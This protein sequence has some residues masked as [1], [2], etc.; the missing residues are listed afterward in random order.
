[1]TISRTF[2][3]TTNAAPSTTPLQG[4]QAISTPE[5]AS[6]SAP[7]AVPLESHRISESADNAASRRAGFLAKHAIAGG[8]FK[9]GANKATVSAATA[10]GLGG[11]SDPHPQAAFD[12]TVGIGL[13]GYALVDGKVLVSNTET[14]MLEHPDDGLENIKRLK[15]CPKLGA[16]YS[17]Y[18]LHTSGEVITLDA[19]GKPV[20]PAARGQALR[21]PP[22]TVDFALAGNGDVHYLDDQGR[23]FK[24]A[25]GSAEPVR[26]QGPRT[27]PPVSI[28]LDYR[29]RLFA[30]TATNVWRASRDGKGMVAIGKP[31]GLESFKLRTLLDGRVAADGG[32]DNVHTYSDDAKAWKGVS[33]K[34]ESLRAF[35]QIYERLRGPR[36]VT[37]LGI[38]P[39]TTQTSRPDIRNTPWYQPV[40]L[41]K[42][43]PG[44]SVME[45]ML[46]ARR[47][48]LNRHSLRA[49]RGPDQD[50]VAAIRREVGQGHAVLKANPVLSEAAR[51]RLEPAIAVAD[52][53]ANLALD[54]LMHR[55]GLIIA[56][57]QGVISDDI[58]YRTSKEFQAVSKAP[59][60]QVHSADNVLYVLLQSRRALSRQV[61]SED[62]PV[63][64]KLSALLDKNVMIPLAG[65]KVVMDG[66]Q[67]AR[68]NMQSL[69]IIKNKY[70]ALTGQILLDLARIQQVGAELDRPENRVRIDTLVAQAV[71]D[72]RNHP[73]T[74]LNVH[75]FSNLD[76]AEKI[77]HGFDRMMANM[78][79][80]TG[81]VKRVMTLK[82]ELEED[83]RDAFVRA[84]ADAPRESKIVVRWRKS[85]GITTDGMLKQAMDS[86]IVRPDGT[87]YGGSERLID[88]HKKG[89]FTW[90][91]VAARDK[92]GVAIGVKAGVAKTVSLSKVAEVLGAQDAS[93]EEAT[94]DKRK[95]FIGAEVAVPLREQER[96]IDNRVYVTINN[97]PPDRL[98]DTIDRALRGDLKFLELL[99]AS[100][101]RNDNDRRV[102]DTGRNKV[103]FQGGLQYRQEDGAGNE[104]RVGPSAGSTVT[105]LA[106]THDV[107]RRFGSK[108]AS[109]N[110]SVKES[111]IPTSK[112]GWKAASRN[113][114]SALKHLVKKV[115]VDATLSG[116]YVV[117]KPLG[118]PEPESGNGWK[119][120]PF[121]PLAQ[122]GIQKFWDRM[123][124]EEIEHEIKY[125]N[126]GT[127]DSI[128][129]EVLLSDQSGLMQFPKIAEAVAAMPELQPVIQDIQNGNK[130]ATLIYQ[131][132][133]AGKARIDAYD[134]QQDGQYKEFVDRV[135]RDP[136][137]WDIQEIMVRLAKQA[138]TS[139]A[140]PLPVTF[141]SFAE[142][143]L[144]GIHARVSFSY[145]AQGKLASHA[146]EGPMLEKNQ[147]K[148]LPAFA[149]LQESLVR[150][151]P[152]DREEAI[153]GIV[154]EDD[155][156]RV[157]PSQDVSNNAIPAIP[158]LKSEMSPDLSGQQS[159]AGKKRAGSR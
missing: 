5:M 137:N 21:L 75:T 40:F 109:H 114:G 144:H 76:R 105:L 115:E 108:L 53:H 143:E 19:Q 83:W 74:R 146:I 95:V 9:G 90:I 100:N 41:K 80:E 103:R 1:M 37:S 6:P 30:A 17:A 10:L 152:D 126:E 147:A 12:R 54:K 26:V 51:Q 131:I 81:V 4:S 124:S 8:A 153:E 82:G 84:I 113:P 18:A 123:S 23:I 24:Q 46:S 99:D 27:P 61:G 52:E 38:G 50:L 32:V 133:Q 56:S 101:N 93:A 106:Q 29:D 3:R 110:V 70:E 33:A 78:R 155:G 145:D 67:V 86:A 28:A 122:M 125:T 130:T 132:S 73:L 89:T 111:P 134:A 119:A 15:L 141:S 96:T 42:R 59:S 39:M 49:E 158:A 22:G 156:S 77:A 72:S 2:R 97:D 87:I 102:I 13:R 104:T 142:V 92:A 35:D 45:Q 16:S 159:G 120:E 55:L 63:I 58:N 62:D 68:G 138:P 47:A 11:N 69:G 94:K 157:P 14:G 79:N 57:P 64:T 149:Q 88:F 116:G 48:H 60:T 20:Q 112:D 148:V 34:E 128:R 31:P 136:G 127:F 44:K 65:R 154:G 129:T 43:G 66:H 71:E 140:I 117:R 85:G 151:A 98:L 139:F 36:M 121:I 107:R 7:A 135:T 91:K 150:P 118:E 25:P